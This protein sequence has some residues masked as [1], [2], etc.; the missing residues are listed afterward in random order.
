VAARLARCLA[1]AVVS[2]LLI[3]AGTDNIAGSQEG[4]NQASY[5][6]WDVCAAGWHLLPQLGL[7]DTA[8]TWLEGGYSRARR[9]VG[10]TS[11]HQHTG[12]YLGWL[13]SCCR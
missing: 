12:G 8:D 10:Y 3:A 4:W 2:Q 9:R 5:A 11:P 7:K 13:A 6:S 1:V